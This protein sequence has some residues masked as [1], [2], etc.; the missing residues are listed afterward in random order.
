MIYL[1]M[2]L[3]KFFL[4]AILFSLL[5]IPTK[6]IGQIVINEVSAHKGYLD[7]YGESTDWIEITNTLNTSF[8]LDNFYISD[9]LGNLDK[10]QFPNYVISPNEK[11]I[12]CASGKSS[13]NYPNHWE[14]LVKAEEDWKYSQGSSSISDDWNTNNFN[15]Q[16]WLVGQGGFGYGDND[17][18]TII[19]SNTIS[20]YLRKT[21]DIQDINDISHLLLHA[22]YDDG[23][24]AYLNG[25]EIMRSNNFNTFFP[26]FNTITNN[27]H[28]AVLYSG[29]IP[30]YKIFSFEDISDLLVQGN[31]LLA[32]QVHNSSYTSSDLS[33]NFFLSAG[34]IST[35]TNYQSLPSW[36]IPP[37]IHM[38]SNFKLSNGET[39][40]I[41]NASGNISDSISVPNDLFNGLS[42][43]RLPD[44]SNNWCYF[45]S[46]TPSLSNNNSNCYAGILE[47]PV[48]NPPSG[49][50]TNLVNVSVDNSVNTVRYTTNGDIPDENDPIYNS[51]LSFN[52]STVFS[53]RSFANSNYIPS[54]VVDRTFIINELNHHLSVFS[55]I[56]D[57][58]N[59]WD[60]NTGIY[61]MGPN[62][63]VN[64]Y[65]HFGSNFW[66]PWSKFSRIEFF[67]KDRIKQFETQVDL[68]IHGGWSRAEPQKSFRIDSKSIYKGSIDYPLIPGKSNITEYNNFNLRNGGQHGWNDRIQDGIISRVVQTTNIDRMG[69]EPAIVYLNGEYWGLYGVREKIDE[70]Y[71]ESNH[72]ISS[73]KVDLLNRDSALVGTS[74]HFMKSYDLLMGTPVNDSSFLPLFESRFDKDNY[75][76]YFITQ[77]YIQNMD[78]MGIAWGLNNVKIWRPDTTGGKWRYVLYDTDASF[79]Y[80][81]QNIY[82]NYINYA[83]FPSVSSQHSQIFNR[84]LLNNEFKCQFANRYDDLINTIF[85]P[86]N[87]NQVSNGLKNQISSAIPDHI[88]LWSS[89]GG[90]LNS[91]SQ[92]NNALSNISN[93]NTARINTARIHLNQ[94]LNLQGQKNIQL[95]V[96]PSNSGKINISTVTPENYPWNGVYHGGC[97]VNITAI[98]DSGFTFSHWENNPITASDLEQPEI[99]GANLNANYT[100]KAFFTT[101]DNAIDVSIENEGENLISNISGATGEVEYQWYAN[102]QP[103]SNDSII[104]NP[105]NGVYKLYINIGSC[106]VLSDL[107][108]YQ[109]EDY[110]LEVFPNPATN[111]FE[112]VFLLSTRQDIQI[113]MI[114]SLGQVVYFNERKDFLGQFKESIDVS[115]L[116]KNV[117]FIQL[118]TIDKIY[119]EKIVVTN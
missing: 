20:I 13:L 7:E 94:S 31:N 101:C 28:E 21:F 34:I 26:S 35:N 41:S 106:Q 51:S 100:F 39:V 52:S 107:F 70:H 62:A 82:D 12:I 75:I 50:Y 27:N 111:Q 67:N 48:I 16:S 58:D 114:N 53:A 80:F 47:K 115:N 5:I 104:Y 84:I 93:Y 113:T 103:I 32:I 63:D 112:L 17:D 91:F 74:N 83:R 1:S 19:A 65:P 24:V 69:Y 73:D 66:Q 76:D 92:W 77:T 90:G 8:N 55:I 40:I 98:P 89:Q 97:P 64:N 4:K 60:W 109:Q 78:W 3:K 46:P 81:G 23:F 38:H 11:L 88:N 72:G 14:S 59:L 68:E 18:N 105:S 10:W 44:I 57:F 119:T 54:E 42:Y 116:S 36:L 96:S 85:Q 87:F 37:T 6:I 61:V 79:G 117:Y 9:E 15:D 29:G 99:I 71:V 102:G 33:S 30:E 43:G 2:I 22:D 25:T 86:S 49:W 95:D 45:N 118:K 56:T 108:I 110:Q